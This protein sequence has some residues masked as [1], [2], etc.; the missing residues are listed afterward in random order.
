MA[1]KIGIF[2]TEQQAITAIQQLEQAGFVEGE[3]KVLA[4]DSEHSRRIEAES[5]VHADELRELTETSDRHGSGSLGMAAAAGFGGLGISAAYGVAGYGTA[6]Y[7]AG[8]Y[9]FAAA[10][11]LDED[12]HDDVLQA[13]GMDDDEA[14]I[15]SQAL[16]SGSIIVIVETDERKSLFDKEGG[17]DLTRLGAAEAVFRQCNA[18]SIVA[19]A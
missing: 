1:R 19:G 7:M 17:P 3:L 16:Q 12:E 18:S 8:G 15:C 9:P 4:K 6:P 14:H 2:D 10:L 5:G 13:F 11:L